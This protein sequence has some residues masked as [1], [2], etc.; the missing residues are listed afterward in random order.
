MRSRIIY[1]L[2]LII[3]Y[4]CSVLFVHGSSGEIDVTTA[5]DWVVDGDTF[6]TTSGDRIRL[7]DID[8]PEYGKS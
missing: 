4:R 3:L 2:V 8:A 7:A 1:F 6:D 5:V